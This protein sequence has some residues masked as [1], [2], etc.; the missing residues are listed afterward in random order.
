M[1]DLLGGHESSRVA[2]A[3][4]ELLALAERTAEVSIDF[5]VANFVEAIYFELLITA[6]SLTPVVQLVLSS[7]MPSGAIAQVGIGNIQ[8]DVEGLG[9][10]VT[11]FAIG[12]DPA[13]DRFVA[14]RIHAGMPHR[15]TM[16]H[17]D[18]DPM[19]YSLT[20]WVF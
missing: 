11:G 19:T 4:V 10:F 13:I 7:I 17:G 1:T 2:V 18:T 6:L 15:L 5:E 3:P 9:S 20:A 12:G 16:T 14:A 8:T